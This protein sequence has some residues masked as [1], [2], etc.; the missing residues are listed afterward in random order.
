MK[1]FFQKIFPKM[2]DR[3]GGSDIGPKA[4]HGNTKSITFYEI[5]PRALRAI[6]TTVCKFKVFVYNDGLNNF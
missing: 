4:N 3:V 6:L 1:T 5:K 2:R